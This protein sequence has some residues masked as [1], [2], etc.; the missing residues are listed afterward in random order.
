[1]NSFAAE[2]FAWR[3]KAIGD[4]ISHDAKFLA[5]AV[6]GTPDLADVRRRSATIRKLAVS[7]EKIAAQFEA[8]LEAD[9]QLQQKAPA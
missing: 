6:K 8:V 3:L 1:M 2:S 4:E 9:D 5:L 7:V